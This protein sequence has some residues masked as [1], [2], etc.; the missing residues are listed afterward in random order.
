[1]A[2]IMCRAQKPLIFSIY[3]THSWSNVFS[4]YQNKQLQFTTT[5]LPQY[6]IP[7]KYLFPFQIS[8]FYQ[9]IFSP[10]IVEFFFFHFRCY[11][12]QYKY[13]KKKKTVFVLT[14]E[15]YLCFYCIICKAE[16]GS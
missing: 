11:L 1:M 4:N 15:K 8:K 6:F 10:N 5:Y 14:K 2:I 13:Y 7:F 3:G 12:H 16:F 9:F